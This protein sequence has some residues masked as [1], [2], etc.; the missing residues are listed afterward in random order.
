MLEGYNGHFATLNYSCYLLI[1]IVKS[2]S[3]P[4]KFKILDL[5]KTIKCISIILNLYLTIALQTFSDET[6]SK[7][8]IQNLDRVQTHKHKKYKFNQIILTFTMYN[9]FYPILAQFI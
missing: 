4:T 9:A 2:N 1:I 8:Y 3:L 6:Y 5:L 7:K